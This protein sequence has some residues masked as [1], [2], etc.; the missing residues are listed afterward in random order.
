MPPYNT[1]H[2]L[3]VMLCYFWGEKTRWLSPKTAIMKHNKG[4]LGDVLIITAD[5]Y[6]V[7]IMYP[8]PHSKFYMNYTSQCSHQYY[9]DR[10]IVKSCF[11]GRESE[12]P[13][14]QVS[15]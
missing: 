3:R 15:Y 2:T 7:L 5:I 11:T 4:H 13:S 6:R 10:K 14:Y 8:E 12:I 1:Q 9:K